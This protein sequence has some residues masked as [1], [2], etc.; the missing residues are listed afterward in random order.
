ML[1]LLLVLF[2]CSVIA[3]NAISATKRVLRNACIVDGDELP[4]CL[5]EF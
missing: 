2:A 5:Q 1:N 4:S 3:A